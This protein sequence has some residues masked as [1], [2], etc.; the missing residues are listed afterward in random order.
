MNVTRATSLLKAI[1]YRHKW[2]V[3]AANV[4][5]DLMRRAGVVSGQIGNP[6]TVA[7]TNGDLPYALNAIN[8]TFD[9]YL[10]H[11]EPSD[12]DVASDL[13]PPR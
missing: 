3:V 12:L 8:H 7:Q 2:G 11:L 4:Y 10:R 5:Q 6:Y 9:M 13:I 1:A